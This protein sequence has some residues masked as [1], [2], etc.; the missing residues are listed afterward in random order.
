MI[1]TEIEVEK[2]GDDFGVRFSWM[3]ATPKC[4]HKVDNLDLIF[5]DESYFLLKGYYETID[6]AIDSKIEYE[7]DFSERALVHLKHF[8]E[9]RRKKYTLPPPLPSKT[10][11]Y[12]NL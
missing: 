3:K 2:V 9:V 12:N 7:K 6:V 4:P 11:Y 1:P 8:T 10:L 5:L